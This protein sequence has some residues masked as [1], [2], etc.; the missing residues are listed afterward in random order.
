MA[1]MGVLS[2]FR[3]TAPDVVAEGLAVAAEAEGEG[4]DVDAAGEAAGDELAL[5]D[6]LE[7]LLL[8][9]EELLGELGD[10]LEDV[11]DPELE[12][13][14]LLE[15]PGLLGLEEPLPPEPGVGLG[16]PEDDTA[17]HC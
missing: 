9:L 5:A 15:P 16:D 13:E 6:E 7:E 8:E 4:D 12:P 14:E 2:F 3:V 17:S 1:E 10:G 11:L